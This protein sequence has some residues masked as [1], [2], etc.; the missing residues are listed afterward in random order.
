LSKFSKRGSI[1]SV[2]GNYNPAFAVFDLFDILPMP[3]MAEPISSLTLVDPDGQELL[4]AGEQS[5]IRWRSRGLVD[6][7]IIEYSTDDGQAWTFVNPPNADNSGSYHWSVPDVT[8]DLC[9]VRLRNAQETNIG[10][11]SDDTFTIF[12]CTLDTYLNGDCVNNL[13]ECIQ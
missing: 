6:Q 2:I 10:D 7:V 9:R 13:P 8:S 11:S 12:V 5:A 3:V 4:Q 1:S